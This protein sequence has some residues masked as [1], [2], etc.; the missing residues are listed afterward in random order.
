MGVVDAD[1]E[2]HGYRDV[3]ALGGA[4]GRGHDLAE[5][6]PLERQR[7]AAAAPGHLGHR[8][9]EV[10]VDVI[11]QALVGDHLRRGVGGVRV[12][13]VELQRAR[14]LVRGERRHVHGDRM[15]SNT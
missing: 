7:R 3:G 6:P 14:R 2:L 4:H 1:P 11:G 8:A 15:A 5:Q 9:A 10:H 12:D 13:G